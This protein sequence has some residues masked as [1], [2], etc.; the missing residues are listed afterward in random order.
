MSKGFT[1]IEIIIAIVVV[2]FVA[3]MLDS[4][5]GRAVTGSAAP[6]ERLSAAFEAQSAMENVTADYLANYTS[7]L[8]GLKNAIGTEGSALNPSYGQGTV[9]DNHFITWNSS[10]KEAP[11]AVGNCLEVTVKDATGGTLTQ[12]YTSGSQGQNCQ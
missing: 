1:L 8:S 10:D 9:I 3:V 12:I 11:A 6:I 5:F 7:N 4:Y 2:A